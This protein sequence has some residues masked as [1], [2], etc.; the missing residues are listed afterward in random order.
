MKPPNNTFFF[1]I[2]LSLFRKEHMKT[3]Y[4]IGKLYA[5]RECSQAQC[6]FIVF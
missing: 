5:K 1:N 3:Q 2:G 4:P 6:I